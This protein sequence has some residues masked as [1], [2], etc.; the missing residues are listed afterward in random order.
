MRRRVPAPVS[1]WTS[2]RL[3]PVLY[4]VVAVSV[5]TRARR[6]ITLP[7]ATSHSCAMTEPS[8]PYSRKP[9]NRL[10]MRN[11]PTAANIVM[12]PIRTPVQPE[13]GRIPIKHH[14]NPEQQEWNTD[15]QGHHH[16]RRSVSSRHSMGGTNKFDA[17]SGLDVRSGLG[18]F[19]QG[20]TFACALNAKNGQPDRRA[21]HG[22]LSDQP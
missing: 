22:C 8:T 12:P 4:A 19:W 2:W 18:Q 9:G 7:V 16:E 6:S 17:L 13:P 10:G 3:S 11:S 20:Q 21:D 1:D 15:H 14:R 5:A